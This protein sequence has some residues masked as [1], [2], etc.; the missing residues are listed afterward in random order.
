MKV[1]TRYKPGLFSILVVA[2]GLV[3][4]A[5]A[6]F[7]VV[8]GVAYS[9]SGRFSRSSSRIAELEAEPVWFWSIVLLWLGVGCYFVYLGISHGLDRPGKSW[10][11]FKW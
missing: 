10:K 4:I 2:I 8:T 11:G 1:A 3:P 6:I 5:A 9:G 7:F